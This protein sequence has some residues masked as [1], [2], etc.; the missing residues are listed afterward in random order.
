MA[1]VIHARL[2]MDRKTKHVV[3]RVQ[4]GEIAVVHHEDLDEIAAR[5]LIDK[6]VKAVVNTACSMTGRYPN[7]GPFLLW[8]SR[9]PLIDIEA[10]HVWHQWKEDEYLKVKG[11]VVLY[12]DD[13][14]HG[15]CWTGDL[16]VKQL[17]A[18]TEN[19]A[20]EL[21]IFLE[22]TLD[23]AEREKDY[24]LGPIPN[25]PI[26]TKL[27]GRHALVVVRGSGYV[28]DLQTVRT[29]VRDRCPVLIGVDGGADALLEAGFRP[30]IIVGDM[31]SVSDRALSCG[32]D[33]IVHAYI[34]GD[35]PGWKRMEQLQLTE[36]AH[37]FAFP[38]TSEDIAMLL[39][40]AQGAEL[41]VAVGTH[42]HM[43]DFLEKGRR[44]MGSTLLTRLRVGDRLVD[45]K[46]VSQLHQSRISWK[47]AW[48]VGA[49]FVMPLL[50]LFAVNASLRT[51]IRFLI[52]KVR[53][54]F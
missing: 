21:S 37:R 28:E 50:A 8:Q 11:S 16:I 45:A 51:V 41:I 20:H 24:F 4:P 19:V 1:R 54:W 30:D 48:L 40:Y 3:A 10:K 49:A 38:G 34:N 9:I 46:G 5:G 39:A 17:R 29:Y 7:K 42:T 33:L 52:W 44:G 31:D 22:N 27:A 53:L 13:Q 14:Y 23:F 18:S 35:A 32:A 6:K 43:V 12:K 26:R 15:T 36:R 2:C 47:V 25:V